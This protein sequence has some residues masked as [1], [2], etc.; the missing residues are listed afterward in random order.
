MISFE[1]YMGTVSMIFSSTSNLI[2]AC[3]GGAAAAYA[4]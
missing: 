1:D 3:M 2:L 4:T